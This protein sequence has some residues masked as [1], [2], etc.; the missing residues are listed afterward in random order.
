MFKKSA[1]LLL[2]CMTLAACA[3]S[4]PH[5]IQPSADMTDLRLQGGMATQI[6]LP[7]SERVQSVVTGNPSLVIADKSDNIVN[8]VPTN[9]SG[10]TNLIVRTTERGGGDSKVYQYRLIV[11]GTQ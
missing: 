8:L 10:E 9:K 1:I 7:S 4:E 3:S 5:I 6:E 2:S 11:E